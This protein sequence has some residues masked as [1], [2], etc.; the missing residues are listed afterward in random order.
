[1]NENEGILELIEMLYNMISEAWGVPLGN[2]KCLVDR[3]K[4]L[5]L[6]EEI[7]ARLPSEMA[8]AKRLMSAR[9]EFI[10]N[11]KRE[12][13]SVRKMAEERS[14]QLV[15]E[16]EI[17]RLAKAKAESMIADTEAKT[18]ELRRVANEYVDEALKS[19]EASVATALE[20]VRSSRA[21]FRNAATSYNASLQQQ[22]QRQMEQQPM[23]QEEAETEA[24]ER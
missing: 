15:D 19:A 1:M 5:D 12:A 4:A 11:A 23:Q 2:D 16:Q 20:E 7:K 8:E 18:R 9:D 14:R 6:I 24:D 22:V 21:R 17:V 3:D 10:S 13:E